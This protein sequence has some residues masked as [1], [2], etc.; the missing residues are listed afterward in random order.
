MGL[1]GVLLF[2]AVAFP[3]AAPAAAAEPHSLRY[4]LTV[5]SQDG[6]VQSEFLAEGHL[7]GQPFLRYD[8]QKHRAKP[9][10]Q[11]A[12]NVLGAKTWDTETEDLTENGRDLRR[13]LTHIK[14]QKGGLH[15]LQEIKT[16]C[17]NYSDI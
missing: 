14:D 3:F 13:T 15:S 17:R 8:R 7:D 16:A 1:G 6:S 2:L 10:G 11:W 5:L 9:L 4:N 12:E